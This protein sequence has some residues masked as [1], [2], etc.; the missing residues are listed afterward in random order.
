MISTLSF[1][2]ILGIENNI[3][4]KVGLTDWLTD[5]MEEC[6]QRNFV[7]RKT[8]HCNFTRKNNPQLICRIS[9]P[10]CFACLGNVEML[11]KNEIPILIKSTIHFIQVSSR[12]QKKPCEDWGVESSRVCPNVCMTG[13]VQCKYVSILTGEILLSFMKSLILNS[14][15]TQDVR[16]YNL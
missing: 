4:F 16:Q 15:I 10:L 1:V 9:T 11:G 5:W 7:C 6:Y 8:H 12:Y 2:S 3:S 14:L 13:T